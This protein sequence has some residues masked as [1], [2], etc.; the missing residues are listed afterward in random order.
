MSYERPVLSR[1]LDPL[2][3]VWLS[4]AR[5]LGLT[6]RRDPVIFSRTDGSGMLWLGPRDD[7]DADD[8]VCQMLFH[9]LC[10]WITNG[11]ESFHMED[12]GFPLDDADDPR[13][14][15]CLRLQAWLSERHGL[16]GAL[17]P[18]GKYREYYDK[19]P[20]DVL[21]PLDDSDWEREVVRI[22]AEA[23]ARAQLPPFSP[24]LDEAL[25]A[26]AALRAVV[27]PFLSTYATELEG[28]TLPSLWSR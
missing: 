16:R 14:F 10:H 27:T 2:E 8:T 3:L 22:G 11:V 9:E 24:A 28:D 23:I 17:G 4:T 26:T 19:L 21:A 1:Y 20:D 12:W 18:T 25:A 13:E 5:R 7:L 6:V 15:G